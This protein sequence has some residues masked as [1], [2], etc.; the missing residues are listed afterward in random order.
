M[1]SELAVAVHALV[2][3]EHLPSH[4]ATSDQI[5][6]NVCTNPARIRKIMAMRKKAAGVDTREGADGGYLFSGDPEK[7]TLARLYDSTGSRLITSAWRP[8][9]TDMECV[10][11]SGMASVIDDIYNA[12]ENRIRDLLAGITLKDVID[13]LPGADREKA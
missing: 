3:L 12:A 4:M 13:R 10:I 11:A 1:S 6:E 7:L 5:A 9:N 2:Y 8:G